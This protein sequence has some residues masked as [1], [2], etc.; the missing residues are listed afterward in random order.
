MRV[1]RIG[2]TLVLCFGISA[3]VLAAGYA[4]L[5]GRLK[6]QDFT[7]DFRALR[8][9]F[10][11]TPHYHPNSSASREFRKQVQTALEGKDYKGA[12]KAADAWLATEYMNPFAQLGAARAHDALGEAEQAR[13]HNRVAD[14]IYNSLCLPGQGRAASAPCQVISLDEEHFYLAPDSKMRVG[15]SVEWSIRAG[16][17]EF[18]FTSTKPL[19]N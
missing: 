2:L 3:N 5:L 4:A 16:I 10:T 6:A 15:G 17:F 9:A 18:G 11:Q 7:I 13:F 1:M 12:L 14:G 8:L 19:P